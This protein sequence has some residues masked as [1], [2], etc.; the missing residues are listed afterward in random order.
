MGT[1]AVKKITYKLLNEGKYKI[2]ETFV[3]GSG[4]ETDVYNKKNVKS[5][6]VEIELTTGKSNGVS[7]RTLRRVIPIPQHGEY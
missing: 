2:V 3:A 4:T 6:D 5:I 7:E 1:V